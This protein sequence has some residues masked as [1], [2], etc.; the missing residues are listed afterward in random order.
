[1]S[2]WIEGASYGANGGAGSS[3]VLRW[4]GVAGVLTG[5]AD[6]SSRQMQYL[7]HGQCT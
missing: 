1:M 2:R 5:A 6:P 7:C 3:A 4:R